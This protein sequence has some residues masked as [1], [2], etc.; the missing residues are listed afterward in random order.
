MQPQWWG[1]VTDPRASRSERRFARFAP[2]GA[3]V[4][5]VLLAVSGRGWVAISIGVALLGLL[6][7][8][9]VSPAFR[10]GLERGL[11][12]AAHAI[13]HG[14]GLA[15]SWTLLT[16]VFVLVIVPVSLVML[17]VRRPLGRPRGLKGGGWI[18]RAALSRSAAAPRMFGTE[19]GRVR[20]EGE[21][22]DAPPPEAARPEPAPDA[23]PSD[24]AD[25]AAVPGD[26]RPVP[27]PRSDRPR[28]VRRHRVLTAL[29]VVAALVIFDLAIG[30]MFTMAG[31]PPDDRGDTARD[32]EYAVSTTMGAAP[33]ASEP[34]I[35]EYR[36]DLI[37][38]Q[39]EGE[40]YVPFLIRDPRPFQSRY[41]N[42]TDHER[43]SYRPPTPTGAEPLQ[44]AFFGGSVMFGVGQRDQHTIPSEVARLA[45]EAGIAVEVHNYGLPGWVSWQ[46]T[47]YLERLLAAGEQYDLVV[48]YD[49]FN[50]LLV[51]AIAYSG[52]PTHLGAAT[53]S[54]FARDYHRLHE[55]DP[56]FVDG[57]R[58]LASSY[59]RFSGVGRMVDRLR[60]DDPVG[61]GELA[62]TVPRDQ[63]VETALD[64]Y[65]RAM[66]L[67]DDLVADH[68]TPVRFFWQPTRTGWP[69][70]ITDRLPDGVTD[71]SHALDGS[72][73]EL[74]IDEVHTNE[75]GAR[76]MAAA[77]WGQLAGELGEAGTGP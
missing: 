44:I 70:E 46:E 75:E 39:L 69:P 11:T 31:L 4:V 5:L 27:S 56:T 41:L 42:T 53:L 17:V 74:Y 38:F 25:T 21:K 12:R 51:Q 19:P 1:P 23:A 34:W 47:L 22:D 52:G 9:S 43:V 72:E 73:D 67:V 24:G 76:R 66:R 59:A 45:E 62:P 60:D 6:Q 48:F 10:R 61:E 13:A 3:L 15:L 29:G 35:D 30:G 50:D 33:I 7:A 68:D 32:V 40:T 71:V 16:L 65:D 64:V 49:G 36:D 57:L 63:Q 14:V 58:E 77:L 2:F 28:R 54:Q 55:T 8:R 37:D 18:P 20:H 26:P